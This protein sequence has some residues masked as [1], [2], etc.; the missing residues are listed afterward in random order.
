VDV[1]KATA[2][3]A[4]LVKACGQPEPVTLWVSPE[5]DKG[6]QRAARENRVLTV[7]QEPVGSRKDFAVV[8][9]YREKNVSYWIFPK[10]LDAFRGK[11]IIG[12]DY[13]LVKAPPLTHAAV[14]A[15][16]PGHRTA[17]TVAPPQV[18]GK[19]ETV[20]EAKPAP[21]IPAPKPQP[22]LPKFKVIVRCTSTIEVSQIVVSRSQ[23]EA[24]A[25]ALSRM[26]E[27]PLDFSLGKQSRVAVKVERVRGE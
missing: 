14:P 4:M 19:S 11:R 26:R 20:S 18:H 22:V 16:A 2:R 24:K 7:K 9:F 23:R 6:F 10:P 25:Q 21:T 1:P 13:S 15:V 3:L 5:K 27:H 12:I 17:R 8:G